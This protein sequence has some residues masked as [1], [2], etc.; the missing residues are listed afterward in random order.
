MRLLG[1]D[2]EGK[3]SCRFCGA[4]CSTGQWAEPHKRK[5]CLS[6]LQDM[7]E[8]GRAV[9]TPESRLGDARFNEQLEKALKEKQ[10]TA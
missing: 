3:F 6:N 2:W 7:M 5:H 8:S 1:V 10:S 4:I 9:R